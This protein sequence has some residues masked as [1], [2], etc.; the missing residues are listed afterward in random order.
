MTSLDSRTRIPFGRW[1]LTYT[2]KVV[3]SPTLK[4]LK[5]RF[6]PRSIAEPVEVMVPT[7][8]GEVRCFIYSPH[9]D[10][11]LATI[12]LTPPVH[13]NIHGG[14]FIFTNALQD[15]HIARYIAAEVGAFVVSI[16]YST[17][18]NVL[19][20]VAEE[21]CF[22]VLS[23]LPTAEPP[24]TGGTAAASASVEEAPA[25]NSRSTLSSSCAATAARRSRP[26][27]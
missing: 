21:Q 19:F 8:H 6:S 24:I 4:P 25:P 18:P 12:K 3:L 22:D 17:A 14:G 1:L 13:I 11:P 20:P 27:L 15:D 2:A 10:A 26:R 5:H 9:P 16:D 23:G 7:R